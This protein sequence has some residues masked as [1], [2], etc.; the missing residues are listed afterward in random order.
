MAQS[1]TN[2]QEIKVVNLPVAD[3]HADPDFNCRGFIAPVDVLD[4]ARDVSKNGLQNPILVQEYSPEKKR[5]TSKTHRIISGHR[6]HMAFVVNKTETIP[7]IVKEGLDDI[8]A[9]ILNLGENLNRK[10]LNLLQE[11]HALEKLKLAGL[12]QE[13]VAKRLG[14][15]RPWVQVRFY[16]L[17]FPEDI[18]QEIA[19]GFINQSQIHAINS[20]NRDEQ[21][22][23]VKKIKE[24]KERAGTK[25]L[26]VDIKKKKAAKPNEARERSKQEI[27]EMTEHL[28]DKFGASLVTRALAW[29]SGNITLLD[30]YR[31]I[32]TWAEESGE[33]YEIPQEI[34]SQV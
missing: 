21:Y 27:E 12:T 28:V 19:A 6:R 23:A 7:C 33:R 3:L 18:Q 20:M 29:A 22:A 15:T 25:R 13:E 10:Q 11:A 26:K 16:V 4:L 8:T 34:L 24:A 17:D 32:K 2:G 30:F 5:E 14:V 1:E 31:D 9:R